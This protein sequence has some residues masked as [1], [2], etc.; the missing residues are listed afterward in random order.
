MLASGV[1]EYSSTIKERFLALL[2]MTL[3][4]IS[5]PSMRLRGNS[6]RDLSSIES[7]EACLTAMCGAWY[8]AGDAV[9]REVGCS[10]QEIAA[11]LS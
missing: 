6:M 3:I 11:G 7:R 4:V 8:L 2:G 9:A 5:N 1:R 10:V